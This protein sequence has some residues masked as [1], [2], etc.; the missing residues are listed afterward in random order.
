M[1]QTY[2]SSTPFDYSYLIMNQTNLMKDNNT[3][4]DGIHHLNL[5]ENV[6]IKK[7]LNFN[8]SITSNKK[9]FN[10]NLNPPTL[11]DQKTVEVQSYLVYILPAAIGGGAFIIAL[12]IIISCC[13]CS[14]CPCYKNCNCC[15]DTPVNPLYN[16]AS[17][18]RSDIYNSKLTPVQILT[19][20]PKKSQISSSS[21]I[22]PQPSIN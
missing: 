7:N 17:F 8:E 1:L 6:T 13:C 11:R 20:P 4:K 5:L 2:L 9:I 10:L 16:N 22:S 15:F 14:G 21:I 18:N 19:S 12:I 3:L